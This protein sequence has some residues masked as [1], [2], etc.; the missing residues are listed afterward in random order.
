MRAA[1]IVL[2]NSS[3]ALFFSGARI[4]AVDFRDSL[5]QPAIEQRFT[6]SCPRGF[7]TTSPLALNRFENKRRK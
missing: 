5:S 3:L 6:L 7:E 4:G 1:S 2:I